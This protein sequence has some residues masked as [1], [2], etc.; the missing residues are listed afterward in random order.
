MLRD[1]AGPAQ[2]LRTGTQSEQRTCATRTRLTDTPKVRRGAARV[3]TSANRL[4]EQTIRIIRRACLDSCSHRPKQV[5]GPQCDRVI[6]RMM[7]LQPLRLEGELDC[8]AIELQEPL[9]EGLWPQVHSVC[10]KAHEGWLVVPE[11]VRVD[12]RGTAESVDPRSDS[13]PDHRIGRSPLQRAQERQDCLAAQPPDLR[14]FALITRAS[15]FRA[16]SPCSAVPSVRF[17][18]IGSQLMLHAS[19]PRPVTLTQLRFASFA[20]INLRRDLHP[21]ECAHAGRTQ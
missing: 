7:S 6:E 3:A 17:L 9:I 18:Y 5:R 19:F 2:H 11:A 15:R 14:R 20:V 12:H 21:Q 10:E 13:P 8:R 4:V 16:R 1:R